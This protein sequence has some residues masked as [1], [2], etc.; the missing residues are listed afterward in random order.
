VGYEYEGIRIGYVSVLDTATEFIEGG[1][2]L[3]QV[4]ARSCGQQF[5]GLGHA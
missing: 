1:I 2:Y 3:A 5:Y 4:P